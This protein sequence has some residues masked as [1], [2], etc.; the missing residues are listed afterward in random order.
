MNQMKYIVL[1]IYG[2][3]RNYHHQC[4]LKKHKCIISVSM[5]HEFSIA[6]LGSH[7]VEIKVSAEYVMSSSGDSAKAT[8]KFTFGRIYLFMVA[9]G[10][11][12][13][14][15]CLFNCFLR[16]LFLSKF[17]FFSCWLLARHS[18]KFLEAILE[19]LRHD[20]LYFQYLSC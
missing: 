3:V 4:S 18:S 9:L 6:W 15:I 8:S 10:P 7:Q 13:G 5:G 19:S 14:F 11:C 1:V 2:C 17:F 16:F 20:P 12:F